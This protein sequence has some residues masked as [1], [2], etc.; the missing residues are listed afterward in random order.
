MWMSVHKDVHHINEG[1]PV[2]EC[3]MV[4]NAAEISAADKEVK[5]RSGG[6]SEGM[7]RI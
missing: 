7:H 6:R 3:S 1:L 5:T 2:S 4:V